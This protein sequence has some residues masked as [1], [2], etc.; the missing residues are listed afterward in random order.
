MNWPMK[1]RIYQY[2]SAVLSLWRRNNPDSMVVEFLPTMNS[3]RMLVSCL[4][5][6]YLLLF[7]SANIAFAD[8]NDVDR[9]QEIFDIMNCSVANPFDTELWPAVSFDGEYL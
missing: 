4:H 9:S 8:D 1:T 5:H 6:K 2:N 3:L 7:R